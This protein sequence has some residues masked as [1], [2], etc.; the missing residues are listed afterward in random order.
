MVQP[1]EAAAFEKDILE[2]LGGKPYAD[3]VCTPLYMIS[4]RNRDTEMVNKLKVAIE[5][6]ANDQKYTVP[7]SWFKLK[8]TL[9]KSNKPSETEQPGNIKKAWLTW[10]EVQDMAEQEGIHDTD[11]LRAALQFFHNVGE[12]VYFEE[13]TDFI[14]IDPQW[15]I[16]MLS[17][18][19]TIPSHYK[20]I[21]R[22]HWELLEN[23]ALLHEDAMKEVW[24]EGAVQ[25]LVD[26][27]MK[28]ALL[29]PVSTN[30][31]LR[32]PSNKIPP[33]KVY[34]VPSLLP[35]KGSDETPQAADRHEGSAPP[36]TLV[37]PDNFIP[38]GLTSR[39][40]TA[41][42]NEHDWKALRQIYK[43]AAKF[44]VKK[45]GKILHIS[46]LQMLEGIKVSCDDGADNSN[47][48]HSE[49]LQTI[50]AVLRK[51]SPQQDIK[52]CISCHCK[53]LIETAG[54]GNVLDPAYTCYDGHRC[55]PTSYRGWF[56]KSRKNSDVSILDDLN[57]FDCTRTYF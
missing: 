35:S 27:M 18:V 50:H 14:V 34:L 13:V 42:C 23:E 47:Q 54:P 45:K 32:H 4:N 21:Q 48:L 57:F 53:A 9:K 10:K 7:L 2:F 37:F 20:T 31:K 22:K 8:E 11:T 36:V 49:S 12:L 25:G 46:V 43:D 39:L 6:L 51:L 19:I 56:N 41:L 15:L 28:Y 1:H 5:Q 52:V 24:P 33:G 17:K 44:E 30:Y 55:D 29:L 40:I 16:D 3:H 26:I 38:V